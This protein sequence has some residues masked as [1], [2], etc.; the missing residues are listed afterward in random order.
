MTKAFTIRFRNR[1]ILAALACLCLTTSSFAGPLVPSDVNGSFESGEG[2]P[3]GWVSNEGRYGNLT[4]T[5]TEGE[6]HRGFRAIRAE[7]RKGR[8][9]WLSAAIPSSPRANYIVGG[10]IRA[11]RGEGWLEF[12]LLDSDGNVVSQRESPAVENSRTWRYTAVETRVRDGS[13]KRYTNAQIVFWVKG[14]AAELDDVD[15]EIAPSITVINGEFESPLDKKGR[16]PYWN[17][18]DDKALFPGRS[19]GK[20]GSSAEQPAQGTACTALTVTDTWFAFTSINYPVWEWNKEI[21]VSAMVRGEASA[22]VRLG[23][24]WTD[25]AQKTV[26]VDLGALTNGAAWREVKAGPFERPEDAQGV[27]PLLAVF[28]RDGAAN[29]EATAWFDNAILDVQDKPRVRVMVNQVGY[30]ADGPKT[31]IVLTN[32]FPKRQPYGTFDVLDDQERFVRG[33]YLACAGRMRGEKGADWGWYFWRCDFSSLKEPGTYRVEAHFDGLHAWFSVPLGEWRYGATA[34]LASKAGRSYPFRI[35][36]DIL[37]SET[38]SSSVDFFHAQRCG[39]EVPGWH[40]ACHLDDA[41]MPDGTH[42]DLT[43]GWHSAGDYNKLNWEYGDGSVAYAL[44]NAYESAPDS[45]AALD[46]DKD[47]LCD[48]LD[49]AWWGAK[50]LAKV[51]IPETGGVLNHIEQGPDKKTW[52]Q[53]CPPQKTT[54]NVVGTADDPIVTKGEGN[55]PLAIGAWARLSRLLSSRGIQNDYLDRAIRLWEHATA[56]GTRTGEPLLLISSVDL[57]LVTKNDRFL[58][59]SRQSAEVILGTGAAGGQLSGGYG[60]SGDIP[61]AALAHFA[62]RLPDEPLDSRIKPRLE[63]HT[64][65]FLAEAD[66]A[67]GLMMQKPGPDGYFFDPS[68][69]LGCNYQICCRAWSAL[70]TYRVTR[71]RRLMKYA[72]NQLNFLLGMNPYNLCMMEGKGSLNLPRYHHRYCTIPGHERGAVP[73]AIP[74]GFVRDLGGNDRP[75]VDLSTGGRP[76]PSY[77]TNEPW[78]VHNVFYTLAIT[79]LHEARIST[80]GRSGT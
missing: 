33:G 38:A 80:D 34:Y 58:Q 26:R 50:F 73:G 4:C 60:N 49:E 25:S 11:E 21:A 39:V 66:N 47:G 78:L 74:N 9:A 63:E 13:E 14:G 35:D 23:L 56:Q 77:R 24:V 43:G 53:W 61:A 40:A 57:Y 8:P 51:Q 41:R 79:A 64:P 19:G 76:Y 12:R 46:R 32:F 22:D 42:R 31:A 45:F 44:V 59:Y 5:W 65:G 2:S 18:E 36:R 29:S 67:L 70:M 48:I 52:M 68:S 10:W 30:E 72:I 28:K 75:G 6:A 69:A 20:W 16:V 15:F 55:S 62:L 37:F 3:A 27:R 17:E 54:D 1:V 7:S 71:D